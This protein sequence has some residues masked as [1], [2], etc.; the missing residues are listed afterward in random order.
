MTQREQMPPRVLP[1]LYFGVANV[2]LVLAFGAIAWDPR[3]AGG[4]FYHAR[5]AALVHLVTL[6]WITSS[7]LGALY[8]VGPIA[9]RTPMP[10]GW[11]DVTAFAF[12]TV[13]LVGM[14]GH[15]WIQ[16]FGGLAWSGIMVASGTLYVGWR[17]LQGLRVAPID[18]AV[19]L[20]IAFAFA[21]IAGASTMGVLLGFDKV[22]RFLPGFVLTNVFAHAHFAAI[23]WASMMVVG[24]GYRLL[25]MVLPARMPRGVAMYASALLLEVGAVGL[26]VTLLRRSGYS[27][28]FG[29]IVTAGF[30]VFAA[31]VG[32]ML[33]HRRQRPPDRPSPDYA[34][35]HAAQ[36]FVSLVVTISI[37]I[38]LAAVEPSE[39]TMRIAL[40]YGVTALVGFLGQM[41]AGMQV[42][43]LPLLGWYTAAHRGVDPQAIPS[44]ASV[45]SRQLEGA[46]WW[47]WLWG[48]PALA[49]GFLLNAV[50]LLSAGAIALTAA[51]LAGTMNAA[52][53]A[54]TAFRSAGAV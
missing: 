5:L 17:I 24:V 23:G 40:V 3:A 29:L 37:G 2:S 50:P 9:L 47:L 1:W 28:L 48:V 16:E 14:V 45:G 18:G 21:N 4:F 25:P 38:L 10:S 26:F 46:A 8:V 33:K 54:R 22:Y 53:V 35:R 36:S 44:P 39:L 15:F 32:S 34:V 19:K 13:G 20:H 31:H 52:R 7:I 12:V 43:L 49:I 41:V 27:L 6:G 42:R 11:R 30:L 51:A